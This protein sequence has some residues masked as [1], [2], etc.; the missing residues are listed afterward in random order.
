MNIFGNRDGNITLL[1]CR[2]IPKVIFG[3]SPPKLVI[4][5]DWEKVFQLKIE[6]CALIYLSFFLVLEA[7]IYA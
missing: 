2:K 4:L 5:S 3:K 1:I 7:K 6:K